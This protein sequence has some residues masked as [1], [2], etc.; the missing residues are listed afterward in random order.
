MDE[1]LE[2]QVSVRPLALCVHMQIVV[3]ALLLVIPLLGGLDRA[4]GV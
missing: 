4:E 2:S 3:S 1:V